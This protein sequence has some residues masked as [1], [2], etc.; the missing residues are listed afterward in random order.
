MKTEINKRTDLCSLML[1]L[2]MVVSL[3]CPFF[4]SRT[5]SQYYPRFMLTNVFVLLFIIILV[6]QKN[7]AMLQNKIYLCLILGGLILY[8]IASLYINT[9]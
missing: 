6:A 1:K 3:L 2:M 4:T 8:N 5:G 9:R 7:F